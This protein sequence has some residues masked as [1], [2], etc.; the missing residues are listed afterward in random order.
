VYCDSF[1][2]FQHFFLNLVHIVVD[3]ILGGVSSVQE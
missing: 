2:P 3:E 1:L